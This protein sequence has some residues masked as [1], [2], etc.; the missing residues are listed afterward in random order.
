MYREDSLYYF[1]FAV[2]RLPAAQFLETEPRL[3]A[4]SQTNRD[5]V[6]YNFCIT[7]FPPTSAG[8]MSRFSAASK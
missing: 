1:T 6:L 7:S 2:S 8:I 5:T 4:A 3:Q